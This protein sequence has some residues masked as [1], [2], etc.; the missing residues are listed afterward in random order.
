MINEGESHKKQRLMQTPYT[1]AEAVSKLLKNFGQLSDAVSRFGLTLNSIH[2]AAENIEHE[3]RNLAS[4]VSMSR[5]SFSSTSPMYGAGARKQNFPSPQERL[6]EFEIVERSKNEIR[7]RIKSERG[8][9]PYKNTME[10]LEEYETFLEEKEKLYRAHK[11]KMDSLYTT[12]KKTPL[13]TDEKL[14]DY[15]TFLDGK[16]KKLKAYLFKEVDLFKMMNLVKE[17]NRTATKKLVIEYDQQAKLQKKNK[18]NSGP[19]SNADTDYISKEPIYSETPKA[20][21]DKASVVVLDL[22]TG[23]A[24]N[25]DLKKNRNEYIKNADILQIAAEFRDEVGNVLETFNVFLDKRSNDIIFPS[26]KDSNNK[27]KFEEFKNDW[28]AAGAAGTR[29]GNDSASLQAAADKLAKMIA[30]RVVPGVT[31]VVVKDNFDAGVIHDNQ[32]EKNKFFQEHLAPVMQN[33]DMIDIQDVFKELFAQQKLRSPDNQSELQ[34]KMAEI[35][36]SSGTTDYEKPIFT[37]EVMFKALEKELKELSNNLNENAD[38]L[39]RFHNAMGDVRIEALLYLYAQRKLKEIATQN[40]AETKPNATKQA[41]PAASGGTKAASKNPRSSGAPSSGV[42][43]VEIVAPL[44]LPVKI[45]G[46][47]LGGGGGGYGGGD[48]GGTPINFNMPGFSLDEWIKRHEELVAKEDEAARSNMGKPGSKSQQDIVSEVLAGKESTPQKYGGE[49]DAESKLKRTSNAD[50]INNLVAS[51]ATLQQTPAPATS[52]DPF[53]PEKISKEERARRLQSKDLTNRGFPGFNSAGWK[54][55]LA[56]DQTEEVS[57]SLKEMGLSHKVGKNSGQEG[58]DITVYIG[59]KDKA[60]VTSQNIS[61]KLGHLLKEPHGDTL[62]DDVQLADKVMGRF[63]ISQIDNDFNQYGAKGFPILNEDI[64]NHIL[65]NKNLPKEEKEKLKKEY[66]A[67]ADAILKERYG[68]FYTGTTSQSPPAPTASP[69]PAPEAPATPKQLEKDSELHKDTIKKYGF[70]TLKDLLSGIKKELPGDENGNLIYTPEQKYQTQNLEAEIQRREN[71]KPGIPGTV[72]K[73]VNGETVYIGKEGQAYPYSEKEGIDT[74]F[75]STSNVDPNIAIKPDTVPVDRNPYKPKE[76]TLPPEQKAPLSKI[77]KMRAAQKDVATPQPLPPAPKVKP[78]PVAKPN[79]EEGY[80]AGKH[81]IEFG[82][83]KETF[84]QKFSNNIPNPENI[85]ASVTELLNA[86]QALMSPVL[87]SAKLDT[88]VAKPGAE[89]TDTFNAL[90]ESAQKLVS[91]FQKMFGIDLTKISNFSVSKF[92]PDATK[93]SKNDPLISAGLYNKKSESI[94]IYQSEKEEGLTSDPSFNNLLHE[95]IHAMFGKL[96][97]LTNIKD[98]GV[99]ENIDFSSITGGNKEEIKAIQEMYSNL[100]Q[101]AKDEFLKVIAIQ[102]YSDST[103]PENI[104]S[105]A[106]DLKSMKYFNPPEEIIA[107]LIG[108]IFQGNINKPEMYRNRNKNHLRRKESLNVNDI[109]KNLNNDDKLEN[110]E[111]SMEKDKLTSQLDNTDSGALKRDVSTASYEQLESDLERIGD[112]LEGPAK[113]NPLFVKLA[114]IQQTKINDQLNRLDAIKKGVIGTFRPSDKDDQ[115]A[116]DR[117]Q[118]EREQKKSTLLNTNPLQMVTRRPD[119]AKYAAHLEEI[120]KRNGLA[121][122]EPSQEKALQAKPELPA[123][124]ERGENISLMEALSQSFDRLT[125]KAYKKGYD[126]HET[127]DNRADGISSAVSGAKDKASS[128]LDNFSG[129]PDILKNALNSE[130]KIPFLPKEQTEEERLNGN[131]TFSYSGFTTGG[132]T[133]KTIETQGEITANSW[134]EAVQ[135]LNEQGTIFVEKIAEINGGIEGFIRNSL[136]PDAAVSGQNNQ[137][138]QYLEFLK[139]KMKTNEMV[140]SNTDGSLTEQGILESNKL[141]QEIIS[142]LISVRGEPQTPTERVKTDQEFSQTEA[143]FNLE[144]NQVGEDIITRGSSSA[145]PL[146]LGAVLNPKENTNSSSPDQGSKDVNVS[147]SVPLDVNVLNIGDLSKGSEPTSDAGRPARSTDKGPSYLAKGGVIGKGVN[148]FIANSF[149]TEDD[150][151]PKGKDKVRAYLA[152]GEAVL[153]EDAV[154]N[155][156][157]IVSDLLKNKKIKY[158]KKG[159]MVGGGSISRS[160]G[161]SGSAPVFDSRVLAPKGDIFG[162]IKQWVGDF[163]NNTRLGFIGKSVMDFGKALQGTLNGLAGFVKAASPDTF[164]TLTGSIQLLIGA[165]GVRFIPII[166]RVSAI[167]QQWYQEILSGEGLVGGLVAKF[168]EWINGMPEDFLENLVGI[169]LLVAGIVAL[170]PVFGA[171]MTIVGIVAAGFSLL[172]SV[173]SIVGTIIRGFGLMLGWGVSM[174]RAFGARLATAGGGTGFGSML[175]GVTRLIAPLAALLGAI[176]AITDWWNKK[177]LKEANKKA[178]SLEEQEMET[179]VLAG[180][181]E[182]SFAE[183]RAK[184]AGEGGK[185]KEEKIATLKKEE[186]FLHKEAET[187]FNEAREQSKGGGMFDKNTQVRPITETEAFKEYQAIKRKQNALQQQREIEEGKRKGFTENAEKAGEEQKQKLREEYA[188]LPGKTVNRYGQSKEVAE[189]HIKYRSGEIDKA[190]TKRSMGVSE[191]KPVI[192]PVQPGMANL[193]GGPISLLGK[194]ILGAAPELPK[195]PDMSS[196][197]TGF[198]E[199]SG[200]LKDAVSNLIASGPN[201]KGKNEE[202]DRGVG[203]DKGLEKGRIN[204]KEYIKQKEAQDRRMGRIGTKNEAADDKENAIKFGKFHTKYTKQ[205]EDDANREKE[206]TQKTLAMSF[207]KEKA[208][209]SFSSVDEAYKKIQVSALGDDPMTAELKKLN[210][211]GM[212][213]ML[214]TLRGMQAGDKQNADKIVAG[215]GLAK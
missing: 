48:N 127:F 95:S 70:Q 167:L 204:E 111:M 49:L 178:Q 101:K 123:K 81:G 159:G 176:K 91:N 206:S 147:G 169:G 174:V 166:L 180:E 24:P 121:E 160:S 154:K 194:E 182:Q 119:E 106:L 82:W 67:K 38:D 83:E 31:K 85:T 97:K 57:K 37:I 92:G 103:N 90:S 36:G 148:K 151:G 79:P 207:S 141:L 23:G 117:L 173:V 113:S 116:Y 59:D 75:S 132:K 133:G 54:L 183:D 179:T 109:E 108:D 9:E 131:K 66:D 125:G 30:D 215:G 7:D 33:S 3:F 126:P 64:S 129:V 143:A 27:D 11:D 201:G 5:H 171:L 93:K 191:N 21:K 22:E 181:S 128:L 120:K 73:D 76:E 100:V 105:A 94:K 51:N 185:T 8:E 208:Q 71:F 47:N 56:T 170:A 163:V 209:A 122:E 202:Y 74:R 17:R 20:G 32:S 55:H 155:N 88:S 35:D 193:G 175:V 189:D 26:H 187:K 192:Q 211:I 102:N 200:K 186:D 137:T 214:R 25:T 149:G 210:E 15:Q 52:V 40:A 34:R 98:L 46:G 41:K 140:N 168:A 50:W 157:N 172:M 115:E 99:E 44:P 139:D 84:S 138:M 124:R 12:D 60:D 142:V 212:V 196:I 78:E 197:T 13:T 14:T 130:I 134:Q 80:Y 65:T 161:G 104:K 110:Q 87:A 184:L 96:R 188:V 10:R 199:L 146:D 18:P 6:I 28:E 136:R 205:K 114:K 39:G 158:M 152:A 89:G 45:V 16:Y 2:I 58:K 43:Q 77:E 162:P 29:V 165:V 198:D 190:V 42:Q 150:E 164:S 4:M 195:L 69:T 61:S 203:L 177:N 72:S 153:P 86:F 135:K 213:E 118:K 156:K 63:E 62:T 145:S 53:N 68:A 19:G 144:N 112:L 107:T 1:G